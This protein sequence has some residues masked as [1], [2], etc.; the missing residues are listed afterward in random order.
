LAATS[1]PVRLRW[2]CL[3][4]M[5]NENLIEMARQRGMYVKNRLKTVDGIENIRGRGLMVG[6]RR[7]SRAEETAQEPPLQAQYFHR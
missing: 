2:Q 4:V 1:W 6:L 3:E 7:A 5:E